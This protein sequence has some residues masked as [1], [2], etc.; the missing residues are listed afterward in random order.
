M[1]AAITNEHAASS[2]P[3]HMRCKGLQGNTMSKL[4]ACASEVVINH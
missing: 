1:N 3:A 2:I 4:S